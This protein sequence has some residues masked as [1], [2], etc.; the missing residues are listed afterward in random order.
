[1][2]VCEVCKKDI[3]E[4]WRKSSKSKKKPLRFCSQKCANVHNHSDEQRKKASE[5]LKAFYQK[6]PMRLS[7]KTRE[8]IGKT[9]NREHREPKSILDFSS[10]TTQKV[11]RRIKKDFKFGCSLCQWDEDICDLHHIIP[12]SKNGSDK[13]SNVTYICPNCH[14]LVHSGKI[15]VEKLISLENFLKLNEINWHNYFYY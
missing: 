6:H 2:T 9:I 5:S 14:R 1:M 13:N 8:K 10:R 7:Q 3:I 12:T 11:L 15:S 4:D